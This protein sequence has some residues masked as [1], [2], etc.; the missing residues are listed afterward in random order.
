MDL[1]HKEGE[2]TVCSQMGHDYAHLQLLGFEDQ[3]LSLWFLSLRQHKLLP[4]CRA[5]L[6]DTFSVSKRGARISSHRFGCPGEHEPLYEATFVREWGTIPG[7]QYLVGRKTKMKG[8][9]EEM[10]VVSFLTLEIS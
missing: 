7:R 9:H 1:I 5:R 4:A 10:K 8:S 6:L 3:I 2:K